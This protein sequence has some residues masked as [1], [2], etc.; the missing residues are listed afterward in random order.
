MNAFTKVITCGVLLTGLACS[1]SATTAAA[2]PYETRSNRGDVSF[3]VTPR[4]PV[5]S[6]F[7]FDIKAD[8]HSGDLAELDL[9]RVVRLEAN[10]ETYHPVRASKLRGHHATASVTF[11]I[12]RVP[13][14][15][16]LAIATVRNMDEI[17]FD[18]P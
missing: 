4:E 13:A 1:S 2:R 6:S 10:G 8:T 14:R 5:D 11:E 9:T 7:T 3:E 18:W 15:F 16:T 12:A 17:R